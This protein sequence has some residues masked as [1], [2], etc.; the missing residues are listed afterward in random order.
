[1]QFIKFLSQFPQFPQRIIFE[2]I[3][4]VTHI[5]NHYTF[6][7]ND[8]TINL[9]QEAQILQYLKE[10][11]SG[12]PVEYITNSCNFYG[13]DFFVNESVLIPRIDTETLIEIAIKIFQKNQFLNI[14][15]ICTGSGCIAI[16]LAKHYENSNVIALDI[17]KNALEV[18]QKNVNNLNVF[19]QITLM[20]ADFLEISPKIFD[21]NFNLIVSNPPYIKTSEISK[22]EKSVRDY[23]PHIALDGGC[24]GLTFYKKLVEFVKNFQN[25][26]CIFEIGYD[27]AKGIQEILNN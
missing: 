9:Q 27:Q 18:C 1:M 5:K 4:H 11:Q 14:L 12:K 17:S 10:I 24:D 8:I 23:E 22:L 19:K 6:I 16:T 13:N 25:C 21:K 15:D 20:Q 2:I 3:S 26:A 7:T